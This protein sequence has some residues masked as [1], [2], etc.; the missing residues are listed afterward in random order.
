MSYS[1]HGGRFIGLKVDIERVYDRMNWSFV[2]RMLRIFEF[3]HQFLVWLMGF[4]WYS[5]FTLLI[6]GSPKEWISSTMGLHKKYALSLYL[7]LFYIKSSIH[8]T[9]IGA[10]YGQ[11]SES[12]I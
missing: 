5:S 11:I 4:V 3:N 8:S 12:S 9:K 1:T 2:E 6:N 10:E 7:L